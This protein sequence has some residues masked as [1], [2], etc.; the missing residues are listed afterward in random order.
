M[1]EERPIYNT[2]GGSPAYPAASAQPPAQQMPPAPQPS[3][4]NQIPY[5]VYQTVHR[6]AAQRR[7]WLFRIIAL[8]VVLA[9]VTAGIVAWR[10]DHDKSSSGTTGTTGQ[11]KPKSNEP[12][13]SQ[14]PSQQA[15]QSNPPL[16]KADNNP[17][18]APQNSAKNNGT[19]PQP[20]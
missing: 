11:Y 8:V 5:E 13:G 19:V 10:R 12:G 2:P 16:P 14:K 9:L 1:F 18:A 4:G 7:R 3:S 15:P 6:P 20:E 17:V